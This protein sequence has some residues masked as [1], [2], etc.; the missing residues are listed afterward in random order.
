MKLNDFLS[1]QLGVSFE[2]KYNELAAREILENEGEYPRAFPI[3]KDAVEDSR[4][5]GKARNY[6]SVYFNRNMPGCTSYRDTMELYKAFLV[7][8]EKDIQDKPVNCDYAGFGLDY[9][10]FPDEQCSLS[11]YQNYGE[12]YSIDIY[13]NTIDINSSYKYPISL[14]NVCRG[15]ESVEVNNRSYPSANYVLLKQIGESFKELYSD[16]R[17]FFNRFDSAGLKENPLILKCGLM[18]YPHDMYTIKLG[19]NTIRLFS[20]ERGFDPFSIFR[21]PILESL[22]AEQRQHPTV[23]RIESLC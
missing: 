21:F 3:I 4:Y 7:A 11:P 15:N 14:D 22:S 8:F 6:E 9:L 13:Q 18:G 12:T 19:K 1:F 23:R 5:W 16:G 17:M 2:D 20:T 10:W